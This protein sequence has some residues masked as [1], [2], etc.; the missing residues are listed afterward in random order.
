MQNYFNNSKVDWK[1]W[2]P[3]DIV[4]KSNKYTKKLLPSENVLSW[5]SKGD[6]DQKMCERTGCKSI[7]TT[8][9]GYKYPYYTKEKYK[10]VMV[11]LKEVKSDF[12]SANID[13]IDWTQRKDSVGNSKNHLDILVYLNSFHSPWQWKQCPT[14]HTWSKVYSKNVAPVR[15]GYRMCYGGQGDTN[16]L[17]FDTFHE[18]VQVTEAVR[19]FLVDRVIPLINGELDYDLMVA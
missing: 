3:N 4:F 5:E 17:D 7:K 9:S 19:D 1:T 8:Q 11:Q 16:S 2:S 14:T 6:R 15:E 10:G 18:L 12:P 13:F